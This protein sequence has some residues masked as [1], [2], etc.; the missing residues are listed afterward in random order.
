MKQNKT[1]QEKLRNLQ[2]KCKKEEDKILIKKIN[3][4]MIFK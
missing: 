1:Y 2:N 4:K 3:Q